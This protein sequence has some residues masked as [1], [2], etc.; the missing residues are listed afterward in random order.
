MN[1]QVLLLDVMVF[2]KN[3]SS[4]NSSS[5]DSGS[6]K[7]GLFG[8]K[9]YFIASVV[10]IFLIVFSS[11]GFVVY[12]YFIK[13]ADTKDVNLDAQ[14]VKDLTEEVGKKIALPEGE[15][16]T[17]ATVTDVSKL[18]G[19]PFFK[20]AKN[21]DKVIIFQSTQKAILYRPSV[22]KII[23]VSPINLATNGA[24]E[25]SQSSDSAQLTSASPSPTQEVKKLKVAFLNST[26]EAGLAKKGANLLD[27]EKFEVVAT[28]N[29]SGEYDKT[30]VTIVNK[31]NAKSSDANQII[32][33]LSKIKAG[34]ENLPK[35]ES[36]PA[37][38]DIV[39]ILG[40]DFSEAY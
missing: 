24:S 4:N 6:K 8:K 17:I 13:K 3:K 29:S 15:T 10:F 36:A 26:V 19:Q 1:T 27:K 2:K 38:A 31:T 9:V 16:P 34:V 35:D 25:V 20:N 28:S 12:N 33:S 7:S 30:T 14:Q 11:V 32:S 18:S 37:G 22:G 5:G 23:D 39:V 40:S 21:G